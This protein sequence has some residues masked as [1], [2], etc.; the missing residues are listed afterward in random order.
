MRT[1]VLL[2][3]T[4]LAVPAFAQ[5]AAPQQSEPIAWQRLMS[6][7]QKQREAALDAAAV[8]EARAEQLA[9]EVAKLKAEIAAKDAK[10]KQ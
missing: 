2:C 4:L 8:A 3:A 6:R 10:T 9:E 1:I 5:D 7:L